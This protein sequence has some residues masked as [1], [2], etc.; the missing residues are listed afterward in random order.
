MQCLWRS[1]DRTKFASCWPPPS[2]ETL[3]GAS[4]TPSCIHLEVRYNFESIGAWSALVGWNVS[5]GET[6]TWELTDRGAL[7][8][9]PN[10]RNSVVSILRR[11]TMNVRPFRDRNCIPNP[12]EVVL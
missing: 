8:A 10:D 2:P 9:R 3:P 1:L 11:T 12:D 6:A 5:G 7:I 4:S